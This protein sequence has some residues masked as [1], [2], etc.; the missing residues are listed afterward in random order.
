VTSIAVSA[1]EL[2]VGTA[3]GLQHY[4]AQL[5]TGF[6]SLTHLYDLR[7]PP[8]ADLVAVSRVGIPAADPNL[9]MVRSAERCMERRGR[10]PFVPCA[11]P[12]LLDARLRV[13]NALW[14]WFA[15][16]D[17]QITGEYLLDNGQFSPSPVTINQ[18]RFP[19]DQLADALVCNGNA[20]TLWADDWVT[21]FSDDTLRLRAGLHNY[22]LTP[23]APTQFICVQHDIPLVNTTI[24]RGLYLEGEERKIWQFENGQWLEITAAEP[25]TGIRDHTDH[26]PVVDHARLRLLPPTADQTYTFEQ[27]ALNGI[28]HA[29]PWQD[30]RVA[31]DDW[32]AVVLIDSTLWAATPVGMVGFGY[33]PNQ[34][35]VLNGDSVQ[36]VREP[37]NAQGICNITDMEVQS[38]QVL[39]RCDADSKQVFQGTLTHQADTKVF[40]PLP[41]YDPFAERELVSE[42]ASGYWQWHLRGRAGGSAGFLEMKLHGEAL[43]LFD[44]RFVFDTINS[45]AL[46]AAGMVESGTEFGGW[47]RAPLDSLQPRALQRTNLVDLDPTQ[48]NRVQIN[49]A[50][51]QRMLCL[52]TTQGQ[53]IRLAPNDSH[54]QLENCLEYLDDD[55]LWR[56]ERDNQNLMITAPTSVGGAAQR[57]LVAGRFGDDTLIGLPVTGADETGIFY[58]WPTYAGVFRMNQALE[59]TKVYGP[60]FPG[61]PA[62]AAPRALFLTAAGTPAYASPTFLYALDEPRAPLATATLVGPEATMPIEVFDGA[63]DTI[64][65]RW[66]AA[67]APNWNLVRQTDPGFLTREGLQ[68]N[69]SDFDKFNQKRVAWDDPAPWLEL[70]F[71]PGRIDV[72]WTGAQQSYPVTLPP[73]FA[74]IKSILAEDRL[75]LIGEHEILEVNVERAMVGAFAAAK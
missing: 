21:S 35:A 27:R 18:G 68:I 70:H 62:G 9:L 6:D 7:S 73:G 34:Q 39:A 67:P 37:G 40:A 14:R 58:L 59:V 28:W 65:V 33:N 24:R 4:T 32:H 10:T 57:A 44:G 43:E 23:Q 64:Q 30:G 49:F 25:L 46:F 13:Q 69:V 3:A 36:V 55:H 38:G 22:Q 8:G 53:F 41:G 1:N 56:Y 47:F 42:A 66:Q 2:Y 60:N 51:E 16:A 63:Y 74:L 50:S 11:A 61:L 29:L 15:A 5:D 71:A 48:F 31:I 17:G 54:E 52:Q 20:Y 12:A 19:H 72:T 26:P 75:L 45:L